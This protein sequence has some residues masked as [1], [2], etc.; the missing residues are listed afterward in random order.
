MATG[1]PCKGADIRTDPGAAAA[2]KWTGPQYGQGFDTGPPQVGAGSLSF[3]G[4]RCFWLFFLG[5]RPAFLPSRLYFRVCVPVTVFL[6][7]ETS[8]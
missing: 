5:S 6:S 4:F 7:T 1:G 3:S 8:L 2:V